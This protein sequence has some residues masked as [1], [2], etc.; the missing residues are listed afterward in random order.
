VAARKIHLGGTEFVDELQSDAWFRTLVEKFPDDRDAIA[1]LFSDVARFAGTGEDSGETASE[2]WTRHGLVQQQLRNVLSADCYIMLRTPPTE[3][4]ATLW[5]AASMA[6]HSRTALIRTSSL[7]SLRAS[8]EQ[9]LVDGS[10]ERVVGVR[11]SDGRAIACSTV[12]SATPS[13]IAAVRALLP[14]AIVSALSETAR[15]WVTLSV[16]LGDASCLGS[17]ATQDLPMIS[18]HCGTNTLENWAETTSAEALVANPLIVTIPNGE[19][20]Q[21]SLSATVYAGQLAVD[22]AQAKLVLLGRL[23]EI[24]PGMA[25]AITSAE[26]S[27]CATLPGQ[28]V[29]T[30]ACAAVR[31]LFVT[32]QW[33]SP[34]AASTHEGAMRSGVLAAEEVLRYRQTQLEIVSSPRDLEAQIALGS[35][36]TAQPQSNI[37]ISGMAC[38]FPGGANSLNEFWDLLARGGDAVSR[39][40]ADRWDAAYYSDP[41]GSRDASGKMCC[42]RG[43]FLDSHTLFGFDA[44][45]FGLS[46]REAS[47]M[48]VQ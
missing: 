17:A 18:V 35:V 15:N 5:A 42:S 12:V 28:H 1:R 14:A 11:L 27:C 10:G 22:Y 45:F 39:V 46:A 25:A 37:V 47:S 43:G 40:P 8:V 24:F 31:G 41:T 32:G 7:P 44:S 33:T 26:L 3:C 34:S 20:G 9:V 29:A 21:M 38:R 48:D 4:P 16:V 13:P 36:V 23:E 2:L 19:L 30:P 6:A